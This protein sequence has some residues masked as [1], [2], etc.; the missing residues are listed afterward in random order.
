[1]AKKKEDLFSPEAR[2][3]LTEL[4]YIV[5]AHP[6]LIHASNIL[7]KSVTVKR[8]DNRKIKTL[9]VVL[10]EYLDY[11]RPFFGEARPGLKD[12]VAGLNNYYTFIDNPE[13]FDDTSINKIFSAQGKFRSTILEEFMFLL[14][15]DLLEKLFVEYEGEGDNLLLSGGVEAYTNLCFKAKNL[16]SFIHS[17]ESQVNTKNQD[18]AIYRKIDFTVDGQLTEA[19]IP[20]FAAENKTYVDKTMLEGIMATAEKMKSGN[21]Y[22]RFVVVTECY[23]VDVKVDPAYSRI[24]QIYVLRKCG[25]KDYEDKPGQHRIDETVVSTLYSDT[26]AHLKR[27]WSDVGGKLGTTG[28]LL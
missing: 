9:E 25:S 24:D 17:L 4:E 5:R 1:M 16:S 18:Y 27:S 15:K 26:E 8:T 19:K 11:V 12:V 3:Q 10:P 28:V 6:Q 21:P 14:F 20:A 2:V 22:S 23:D 13:N 7:H